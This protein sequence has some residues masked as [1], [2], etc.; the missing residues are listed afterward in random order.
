MASWD[1]EQKILTNLHN[2][3]RAS[4]LSVL[5]MLHVEA[6]IVQ[7]L[8]QKANYIHG[9]LVN[10]AGLGHGDNKTYW[11]PK[12]VILLRERPYFHLITNLCYYIM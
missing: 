5:E 10:T 1:L 8:H 4:S 12:L 3:S 7:L 11:K 6:R 9:D 2:W